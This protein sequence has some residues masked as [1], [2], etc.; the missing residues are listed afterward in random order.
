MTPRRTATRFSRFRAV[1]QWQTP[2]TRNGSDAEHADGDVRQ[3]HPECEPGRVELIG[4]QPVHYLDDG[5]V[6]T[7]GPKK[8]ESREHEV[9]QHAQPRTD[10][11]DVRSRK[12]RGPF[13]NHHG[14]RSQGR[15]FVH[16]QPHAREKPG[17]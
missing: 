6:N 5:Q 14:G 3:E 8:R 15:G 1:H 9:E 4:V 16:N 7:V 13:L 17:C 2:K 10:R 12:C 11:G